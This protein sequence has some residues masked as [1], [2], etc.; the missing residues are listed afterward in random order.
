[1]AAYSLKRF[2]PVTTLTTGNTTLYTVTNPVV[3]GVL[4]QILV[5]NYSASSATV[6]VYIVPS[7]GTAGNSNIV[8]PAV[9]ISA[10]STITLDI[11]QVMN[12][13]DF[14]VATAGAS[15]AI[16]ISVSGYEA[17]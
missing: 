17:Q 6:T 13:G 5:A 15:S 1:M 7:G 12:Q 9:S 11:T 10:N 3:N 16:N 4:K 2:C 14:L 8:V